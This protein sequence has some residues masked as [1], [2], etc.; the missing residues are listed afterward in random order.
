MDNK[1]K[2]DLFENK[3]RDKNPAVIIAAIK[4]LRD[5]SHFPGALRLLAELFDRSDN[6]LVI[7]TISAFFNDLKEPHTRGEVVSELLKPYKQETI[8]MLA[9]SCWQ[10]GLDFSDYVPQFASLFVRS[11]YPVA[12]KCFYHHEE[13]TQ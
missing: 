7:N 13:S 11:T 10:S 4:T 1:K 12:L 3:F 8:Q 6:Q 2:L 5:E 9:S